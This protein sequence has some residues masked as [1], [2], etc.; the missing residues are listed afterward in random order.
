MFVASCPNG[1]ESNKNWFRS[2]YGLFGCAETLS[3]IDGA[4]P[5]TEKI[6]AVKPRVT[7]TTRLIINVITSTNGLW[8]GHGPISE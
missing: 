6:R 7:P 2:E 3:G 8:C 5:A 4:A 1:S